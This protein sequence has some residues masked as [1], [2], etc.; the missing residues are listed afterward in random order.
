MILSRLV[1]YC[2]FSIWWFQMIIALHCNDFK[3]AQWRVKRSVNRVFNQVDIKVNIKASHYWWSVDFQHKGP[4]SGKCSYDMTSS[5]LI[6]KTQYVKSVVSFGQYTSI[7]MTTDTWIIQMAVL[8][9]PY[10]WCG[11]I[12]KSGMAFTF[13]SIAITDM[14]Y[15]AHISWKYY[16]LW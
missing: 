16:H 13:T 12:I 4:E 10:I 8:N 3:C 14:Q 1:Q 7:I 15:S 11:I 6:W 2:S 9:W 5:C